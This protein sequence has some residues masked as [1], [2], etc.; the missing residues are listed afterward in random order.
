MSFTNKLVVFIAILFNLIVFISIYSGQVYSR[1]LFHQDRVLQLGEEE[2]KLYAD[3]GNT[4]DYD[5][6]EKIEK[7]ILDRNTSFTNLEREVN[8]YGKLLQKKN[9]ILLPKVHREF[10]KLEQKFYEHQKEN[11][12]LSK[13]ARTLANQNTQLHLQFT[14]TEKKTKPIFDKLYKNDFTDLQQM[15]DQMKLIA[16]ETKTIAERA[17]NLGNKSL[18]GD[19]IEY[20]QKSA[21]FY[22]AWLDYLM[23]YGTGNLAK[24]DEA[25]NRADSLNDWFKKNGD[26]VINQKSY[27]TYIKPFDEKLEEHNQ[28]GIEIRKQEQ[29]YIKSVPFF[30]RL[31]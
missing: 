8:D 27:E 15:K 1:L 24:Q 31:I 28:I 3:L 17:K 4:N 2:D 9:W 10:F 12:A 21:D 19:D 25:V 23:V 14:R 20:Y 11:L 18:V 13:E 5:N 29:Q 7:F 16:D 6:T 30:F 22:Q 26:F